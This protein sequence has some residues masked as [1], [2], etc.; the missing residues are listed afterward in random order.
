MP[1]ALEGCRVLEQGAS[2]A[3]SVLGMLLADQ[4]AEV[5]KVE[6]PTGDPLRG[7][8]AFS[9][10]NRGKMS[11]VLNSHASGDDGFFTELVRTSDVLIADGASGAGAPGIGYEDIVA[12]NAGIVY[13]FIPAFIDGSDHEAPAAW[14]TVVGASTGVYADRSSDEA[15]G[16]SFIALPYVSIF[17]AFVAA[18]AVTAAL[19]HRAR[20][21]EGQKVTVPLYD[22][23]FTAMGASLVDRPDLPSGPAV[24]SPVVERFYLC[25]DGRWVNINAGFERALR[26]LLDAIGHPDWYG[27]L[28]NPMLR[29]DAEQRREWS[30]RFASVWKERTAVEWEDVME[31]AGVP[32][33]MCRTIEEWMDTAHARE[34]EAVIG[35]DDPLHGPMRQVGVQVRLSETPGRVRGPAPSLGEHTE[36]V[37]ASLSS[38]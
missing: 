12:T 35:L 14:E 19:F 11:V 18:P 9:V 27:P 28:T 6:P 7:H 29:D 38:R 22:S 16:P 32:C 13:V 30:G 15:D 5:V 20:T 26:P 17:A 37:I 8:P 10:W 23:M 36:V 25:K 33:T 2:V 1:G 21:G 24:L 3:V 31:R 4:G 34:S